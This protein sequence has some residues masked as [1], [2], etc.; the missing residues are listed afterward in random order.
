MTS[1]LAPDWQQV[2]DERRSTREVDHRMVAGILAGIARTLDRENGGLQ[3]FCRIALDAQL[4]SDIGIYLANASGGSPSVIEARGRS[5]EDGFELDPEG[6]LE[7]FRTVQRLG[8]W[9]LFEDVA[10]ADGAELLVV[11]LGPS[12]HPAGFGVFHRRRPA[13]LFDGHDIQLI[14]DLTGILLALVERHRVDR[15]AAS[16]A[17]E[18]SHSVLAVATEV[19]KIGL[20]DWNIVNGAV[21]WSDEH[22]RMEGYEV[23]EIEPSYEAWLDRVHPDDRAAAV[24]AI[25][26]SM[27]RRGL[28]DHTF[29]TRHPD[30]TIRWLRGRGQYFYNLE[31]EPLRMIGAMIDVT[32]STKAAEQRRRQRANLADIGISSVSLVRFLLAHTSEQTNE[33]K[34]A[35]RITPRLEC[36]ARSAALVAQAEDGQVDLEGLLLDELESI[37]PDYARQVRLE[38]PATLLPAHLVQPMALAVHELV[39]NA[40]EHGAFSIRDGKLEIVWRVNLDKRGNR[41]LDLDWQEKDVRMLQVV[42]QVG[43]FGEEFLCH[44]LPGRLAADVQLSVDAGGVHFALRG[45]ELATR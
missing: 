35:E 12:H 23:G 24:K 11:P 21:K 41:I 5:G 2:S 6:L 33:H 10:A 19:A 25:Q 27:E 13:R 9:S 18:W 34:L 31:G 36:L 32:D 44:E 40:L 14:T 16:E 39:C 26:T 42:G 7:L 20:W 15:T 17:Q 29:R 3:E 1:E 8:K 45:V 28:F 4:A 43:G 38:G 37:V 30:G 22:F